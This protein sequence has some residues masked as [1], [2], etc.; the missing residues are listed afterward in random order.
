MGSDSQLEAQLRPPEKFLVLDG[1]DDGWGSFFLLFCLPFLY[2]FFSFYRKDEHA[3]IYT[4]YGALLII[5]LLLQ[6][7]GIDSSF[8]V[9]MGEGHW[10]GYYLCP[11]I[12]L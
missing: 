1:A 2:W 5:F 9:V 11:N 4:R 3:Y 10:E 12:I 7:L 8:V 6:D